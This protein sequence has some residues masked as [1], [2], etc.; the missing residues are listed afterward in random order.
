MYA[1][2]H[3]RTKAVGRILDILMP[4]WVTN[5]WQYVRREAVRALPIVLVDL[6]ITPPKR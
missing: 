1:L 5:Q 3:F 4:V 2:S 6:L